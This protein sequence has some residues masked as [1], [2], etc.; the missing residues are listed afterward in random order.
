MLLFSRTHYTV[1]LPVR[2]G[3]EIEAS[4]RA[5]I[6]IE[7]TTRRR[8]RSTPTRPLL[9]K[10][11]G[12]AAVAG[13]AAT[14][15]RMQLWRCTH[16][17]PLQP[18]AFRSPSKGHHRITPAPRKSEMAGTCSPLPYQP[19][20]GKPHFALPAET[21][22]E[23]SSRAEIAHGPVAAQSTA[24]SD[25]DNERDIC[26]S[27]CLQTGNTQQQHH[28]RRSSLESNSTRE[29]AG[30]GRQYEKRRPWRRPCFVTGLLACW[31]GWV[32]GCVFG[33]VTYL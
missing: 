9:A 8:R 1:T 24:L 19:T 16:R 23:Q 31:L 20:P 22:A 12:L 33:D 10:R 14:N 2:T 15:R 25:D 21:E 32:C 18:A 26:G 28:A 17:S 5:R 30:R 7:M 4:G 27:G 11:T 13:A 3:E 29:R 6:K